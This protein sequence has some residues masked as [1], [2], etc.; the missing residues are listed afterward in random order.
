MFDIKRSRV[1]VFITVMGADVQRVAD[2]TDKFT[3]PCLAH[4]NNLTAKKYINSVDSD[5]ELSD[6]EHLE[7]LSNDTIQTARYIIR[8]IN[9]TPSLANNLHNIQQSVCGTVLKIGEENST[10]W[11]SLLKM[12]E[13][14]RE[15]LVPFFLD[16]RV[17]HYL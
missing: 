6:D 15:L 3:F 7:N 5:P 13:R 2:I 14:F 9:D 8:K 10:R 12:L 1:D 4:F 16:V 11:N 17:H